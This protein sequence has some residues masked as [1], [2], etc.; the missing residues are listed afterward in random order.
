MAEG[1]DFEPVGST[2]AEWTPRVDDPSWQRYLDSLAEAADARR[3]ELGAQLA[4][5]PSAWAVEAFGHPPA[6][7]QERAAWERR[8]GTVAAHR[9]L[10][11]HD[12]PERALGDAPKPGQVETYASWRA[13][14]LALGRPKADAD[15]LE[16]T[17]GR[18]YARVRAYDREKLWV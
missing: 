16:M 11:G 10:T 2:F 12:D 5:D 1:R 7:L 6:A 17:D 18:L 4:E 14:W 8:A 9:E 13:A 15:E 3:E